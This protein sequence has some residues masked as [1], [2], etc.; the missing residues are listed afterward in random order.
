METLFMFV[1]PQFRSFIHEFLRGSWSLKTAPDEYVSS[2][3]GE[4]SSTL[5]RLI[6]FNF[7][8]LKLRKNT[9]NINKI[10]EKSL[11]LHQDYASICDTDRDHIIRN[12]IDELNST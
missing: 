6:M 12:F 2:V 5:Q 9:E 1:M 8:L 4:A 7:H 11:S 10:N 3:V